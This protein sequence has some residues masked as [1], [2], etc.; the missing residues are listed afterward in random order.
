MV[1][2]HAGQQFLVRYCMISILNAEPIDLLA[3]EPL[4]K[5]VWG[6]TS[7]LSFEQFVVAKDEDRLIGCIRIKKLD[8]DCFELASLVVVEEYRGKRIGSRLVEELL[9]KEKGRPVYLLCFAER[10]NFY[11]NSG[12]S[13]IDSNSLPDILKKEYDRVFDKLKNQNKEIVAMV[14]V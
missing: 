9:K 4:L 13:V 5:S 8:G 1:R 2:I 11:T 12:F 6:D 14:Y 10:K 3:I 7:N